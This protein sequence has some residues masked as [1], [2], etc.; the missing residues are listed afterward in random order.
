L[1]DAGDGRKV[2]CWRFRQLELPG[3]LQQI[4]SAPIAGRVVRQ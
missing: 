3:A 4:G 2:R 1:L